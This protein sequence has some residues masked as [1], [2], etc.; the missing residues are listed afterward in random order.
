MAVDIR[1][2]SPTFGKWVGEVLSGENFR[3]LYVPP[4]F[5]HGFCVLS[6]TAHVQYKCTDFYAGTT[7][8]ASSGTIPRSGSTGRCEDP[9]LSDKDRDAPRLADDPAAP[10]RPDGHEPR[11]ADDLFTPT[12]LRQ[13]A[14]LGIAPAE[15]A[16]QVE[17]FR[18]PPPVHPR[19]APLPRR[20][21]HP[22]ALRERP[23]PGSWPASRRRPA[24]GR[25]GKFVPASGAATP[26]VQG[27]ARGPERPAGPSRPPRSGP[28]STTSPASPST[29]TSP[30]SRTA[31]PARRSSEHLLTTRAWATPSCPRGCSKFH[32]YPDG[33]RTPFEEHLVE[34]ADVTRDAEGVCRL[35][36]T[37]SPRARGAVPT[38]CSK[39]SGRATR[40][41]TA[42]ASRS[43]SPT[44]S[45]RPTRWPWTPRTGPSGRRTAR[46]SSGPAATAR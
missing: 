22:H 13:M 1:P 45:A 29:R 25:I 38:R 36:F 8:S 37:V 20:R 5:A 40:S 4:G 7:R 24:R 19:A 27:A 42:A 46:S 15:A 43:P 26:D 33:P 34:A 16:R 9:L 31:G 6:E 2:G 32:R 30:R 14:E 3:Q 39:R 18:N 17:L 44:S 12:D 28:S 23:S 35:H 10:L 21:R 41:A 11:M